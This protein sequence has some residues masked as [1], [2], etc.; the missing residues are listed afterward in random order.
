MTKTNLGREGLLGSHSQVTMVIEGR[1]AR[2]WSRG[3]IEA[4]LPQHGL[5]S[6]LSYLMQDQGW[7]HLQWTGPF[8][9]NHWSKIPHRPIWWRHFST[10]VMSSQISLH[11]VDKKQEAEILG[12]SSSCCKEFIPCKE[13][14]FFVSPFTQKDINLHI[15]MLR[16]YNVNLNIQV[17]ITIKGGGERKKEWRH[18]KKN[19]HQGSIKWKCHHVLS[20]SVQ[21]QKFRL[22]SLA[23]L[24]Q[25]HRSVAVI[26]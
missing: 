25:P 19:L 11:Q 26:L 10:E 13:R 12:E 20:A 4:L 2:H 7:C 23:H 8:H 9:V 3:H 21:L 24:L 15:Q 16:Q 22:A 1:H 14:L 6:L 18:R 17:L 5:L